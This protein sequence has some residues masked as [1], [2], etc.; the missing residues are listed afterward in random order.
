MRDEGVVV[1]SPRKLFVASTVRKL[2]EE[3]AVT[4]V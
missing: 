4:P 1:P 2:A 3:T